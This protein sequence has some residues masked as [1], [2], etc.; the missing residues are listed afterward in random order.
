MRQ[1]TRQEWE[2]LRVEC[3]RRCL[4]ASDRW[5][6]RGCS[7]HK[8]MQRKNNWAELRAIAEAFILIDRRRERRR[9]ATTTN[10]GATS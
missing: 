6:E 5:W 3:N 4:A 10:E 2:A 1:R 8:E 7:H 9:M